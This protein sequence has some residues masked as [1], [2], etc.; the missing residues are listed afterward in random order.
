MIIL[1]SLIS[2]RQGSQTWI[3]PSFS[4]PASKCWSL[5]A[6]LDVL[7][8]FK[9]NCLLWNAA[10]SIFFSVQRFQSLPLHWFLSLK[11]HC[12]QVSSFLKESLFDPVAFNARNP[13]SLLF[14]TTHRL[15]HYHC[16]FFL[17]YLSLEH[18]LEGH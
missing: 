3:F 17:S 18:I 1:L 7:S 4:F 9:A 10:L 12:T 8:L 2:W 16:I 14:I 15:F 11:Q 5:Y 13:F 6:A